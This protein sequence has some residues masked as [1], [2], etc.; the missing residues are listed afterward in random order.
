M[1][2]FCVLEQGKLVGDDM[3]EYH[4]GLFDTSVSDFY[5]LNWMTHDD[6]DAFIT[7]PGACW[8]EGRSLLYHHV[9]KNYEYYIFID[10]DITWEDDTNLAQNIFDVLST[11]NP[12]AG[13]FPEFDAWHMEHR[14]NA[15]GDVSCI[16]GFDLNNH[17]FNRASADLLFPAVYHGSGR[18]FWHAQFMVHKLCPEKH[19]SIDC[20]P[21]SNSRNLGAAQDTVEAREGK[22]P[23]FV[24][25]PEMNVKYSS[26]MS[27]KEFLKWDHEAIKRENA[28]AIKSYAPSDEAFPFTEDILRRIYDTKCND[29]ITR[30]PLHADISYKVHGRR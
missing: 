15:V 2:K 18:S 6:P 23:Y 7:A 17:I 29:Y 5:R 22:R 28:K 10:D 3:V 20:L 27:N 13:C 8:S 11:W 21:I 24:M 12:V 30:K 14:P 9:P 16:A 26:H 1:K 19:L 4:S 25:G